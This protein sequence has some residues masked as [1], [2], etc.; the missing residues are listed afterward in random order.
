MPYSFNFGV[1]A[2]NFPLILW[3]AWL[4]V[5]I[6]AKAMLGGL[7]IGIAGAFLK[8]S[9]GR[10][11]R[12]PIDAFVEIVRNTPLLAQLFLLFFALPQIGVRLTPETAGVLGLSLNCGAYLIEIIRAGIQSISHGQIE[13]GLSLGLTRFRIF[14][15]IILVPALQAVYP[16]LA[17]QFII[18]LLSSSIVSSI[19]VTELTSTAAVLQMSTFRA[20]EIYFGIT[21]IYLVLSMGFRLLLFGFYG[22][23]LQRPS[24][25]S[26]AAR[27]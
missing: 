18:L 21:L 22:L 25:F 26:R 2:D 15:L 16:A 14:R 10:L 1:L 5:L 27:Q 20:F 24:I 3:G 19:S 17:S 4:T 13:A 23:A 11:V 12:L 7:L 6:S 9:G 8:T